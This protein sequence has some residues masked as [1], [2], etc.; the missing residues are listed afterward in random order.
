MKHVSEILPAIVKPE[1]K[2]LTP[3]QRRLLSFPVDTEEIVYQ[4][5]V[6]CQTSMPYRDPGDVRTW[7][8]NNGAVHLLIAAGQALDPN[9]GFFVDV[10]LP[11]GPKPRLV[12]YHLNAE[13]LIFKKSRRP[14]EL[15]DSK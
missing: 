12:L 6:L 5:S 15:L 4:H 13:A 10:G 9:K 14:S 1:M 11:F 2:P 3:I 7:Q 8:S